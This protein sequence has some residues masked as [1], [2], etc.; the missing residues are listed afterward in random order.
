VSRL[1]EY[2]TYRWGMV[3]TYP[4]DI[5]L[6]GKVIP[7]EGISGPTRAGDTGWRERRCWRLVSAA[8]WMLVVVWSVWWALNLVEGRM[9]FAERSWIRLPAFGVDFLGH[10]DKPTRVWL[11]HGDPYE[12]QTRRFSYPPIVT[13]LFTW[14]KATDPQTSLRIWIGLAAICAV[15]GA[16]ASVRARE[17]LGLEPLPLSAGIAAV[18]FSTP[19]LFALERANYDLL[20]VPCIV[21]AAYLLRTRDA[22]TDAAAAFFLA[23]A[24]WA[25]VYPGLL[26]FAL[27]AVSRYR[28]AVWMGVWGLLI[29]ASDI[30]EL[31]RFIAN[32]RADVEATQALAR[33]V[34]DIHPWNHPLGIVWRDLWAGTP[35]AYVPGHIG[36]AVTVGTL[37]LW[38]SFYIRRSKAEEVLLPYLYWT[39]ALASFIP[40]ISN[41][42][43]IT[44]LPLSII[45][46]WS[47]KEPWYVHAAL[48]PLILWWQPM[49]LPLSGRAVMFIKLAGLIAVAVMLVRRSKV[50]EGAHTRADFENDQKAAWT[51]AR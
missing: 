46:L 34:R 12:D 33:V 7:M 25:K 18:L 43:N 3:N 37:F 32:T 40:P 48:A 44:P 50:F 15:I 26:I 23:I 22:T 38:V 16:I 49:S 19:V 4:T 24:A 30:P 47:R 13:R 5:T 1:T 41:D 20:I 45:A 27:L 39:V 6:S 2:N 36:S 14:V 31:M 29:G 35:L 10:V 21:V 8:C 11:A 51:I 17:A 42:Y 9:L 28:A